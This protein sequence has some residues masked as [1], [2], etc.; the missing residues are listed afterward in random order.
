MMKTIDK[1]KKGAGLIE[2]VIASG[3]VMLLFSGI[4]SVF[5]FYLR[6]SINTTDN[7]KAEILSEEG[8]EALR[9]VRDS[10]F[11]NISSLSRNTDHYLEFNGST[12]VST[13]TAE[14]V[15]EVFYRKFRVYD[16]Y[17]DAS[18]NISESG[19]L[20]SDIIKCTVFVS[21]LENGATTTR[22]LSTYLGNVLEI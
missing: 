12:F 4:V 21:W 10:G 22:E 9:V 3:I 17:R 19:T 16:V 6:R 18:L 20:D 7:V 1:T 8:L 15:D 13:T 14:I 5:N 2:V 11:S